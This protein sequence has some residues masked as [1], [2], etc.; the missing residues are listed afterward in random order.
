MATSNDVKLAQ[1]DSLV[2]ENLALKAE[3]EEVKLVLRRQGSSSERCAFDVDATAA[4]EITSSGASTSRDSVMS[5]AF[6]GETPGSDEQQAGSNL[7]GNIDAKSV[8]SS[9]LATTMVSETEDERTKRIEREMEAAA[10]DEEEKERIYQETKRR[11]QEARA[12]RNAS[13]R[14]VRYILQ[15]LEA[16]HLEEKR[17]RD[18][19]K[20][21]GTVEDLLR[22]TTLPGDGARSSD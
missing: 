21:T 17:E 15:E 19:I 8:G 16:E 13:R 9:Y 12:A 1:Y 3:L 4:G 18:L 10:Q 6:A 14:Q 20:V 22:A 5:S 2:A 7:D 11:Q